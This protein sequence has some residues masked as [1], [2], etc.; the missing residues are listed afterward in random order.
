MKKLLF[1]LLIVSICNMAVSQEI[2]FGVKGGVN[3]ASLTGDTSGLESRTA[4][5][6]GIVSE[7]TI[8]EK[9]SIQPELLYS[10][11]GTKADDEELKLN[12]LNIPVLAKYYLA[13]GLSLEAGPQ[14]GLLLSAKTE[15][16]GADEEDIEDLFRD[17]DFGVNFGL[18]YKLDNGLNFSARYYLGIANVY[19]WIGDFIDDIEIRNGVFQISIGYLF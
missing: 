14:I 8:S 2:S 1:V 12:Y 13:E 16:D 18:G 17:I 11:Q 4:F 6:F 3:F 7:F 9:F 15:F 19:D 5:H 10:A